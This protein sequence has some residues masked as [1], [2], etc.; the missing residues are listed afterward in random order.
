MT[1]NVSNLLLTSCI[2][3]LLAGLFCP[4]L[5]TRT[6]QCL[7]NSQ[8]TGAGGVLRELIHGHFG[9]WSFWCCRNTLCRYANRCLFNGV[10]TICI[11]EA[12]QIHLNK[13]I[14]IFMKELL[15]QHCWIKLHECTAHHI[16]HS[17]VSVFSEIKIV[18]QQCWTGVSSFQPSAKS[19]M[20]CDMSC[21]KHGYG[22]L[23]NHHRFSSSVI[24]CHLITVTN[25]TNDW[26]IHSSSMQG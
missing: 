26:R 1:P 15:I 10:Q 5:P 18:L 12:R 9:G 23:T 2:S 6:M 3:C 7:I 19:A 21:M 8:K 20:H 25:D 13:D 24:F 14:I 4:C 22:L 11:S 16:L 17:C